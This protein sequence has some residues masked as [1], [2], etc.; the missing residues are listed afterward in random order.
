MEEE[1]HNILEKLI[2]ELK[3]ILKREKRLLEKLKQEGSSGYLIRMLENIIIDLEDLVEDLSIA[4]DR[5]IRDL[6]FQIG[7]LENDR[8][9]NRE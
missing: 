4:N 9:N 8:E 3:D 6:I 1:I 7:G 2:L 5:E